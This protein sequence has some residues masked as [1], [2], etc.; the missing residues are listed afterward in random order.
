MRATLR[1]LSSA[2]AVYVLVVATGFGL[3]AFGGASSVRLGGLITALV[4]GA[5]ILGAGAVRMRRIQ[6][7]AEVRYRH[8]VEELPLITYID[9]PVRERRTAAYVSP[10]IEAI[11]GVPLDEWRHDPEAF[12]RHLH[13][14]D[15][16]RVLEAQEQARM[17]GDP[18]DIEY[19]MITRAGDVVWLRDIYTTVHDEDGLPWYTQ[20]FAID[21]TAQKI[22]EHDRE[23]LLHQAQ[24]QNDELRRLDRMKDEFIAL[25]SHELRT[26]LT[27]IRGYLELLVEDVGALPPAQ[28][29]W[30]DVIDRNSIRLQSLVED[31][32]LAAQVEEGSLRLN[33]AS[34]DLAALLADCLGSAAQAAAARGIVLA[35]EVGGVGTV[36]GD[37][38]RVA[39]VIDNVVSNALKFTPSGGRV[40]VRAVRN[41]RVVRIDIEDSG[42]GIPLSEQPQ[43][44]T[45]FF[46]G[47][48]AQADAIVGAGLGLSIAKAIVEAHDGS[49][50]FRSA[51]GSGTTFVIELPVEGPV[52][53]PT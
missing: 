16:E 18:L 34:F 50:T 29:G 1:R 28:R 51:E 24:L 13:P 14:Q 11:I 48:R 38:G 17:T 21:I 37:G 8:L 49:I 45:R 35:H 33:V 32:L 43:L 5:L 31:L 9:S 20:G 44:F 42:I 46:R 3:L 2:R 39:Q 26:P 40:G 6:E 25:V 41:G 12:P 7:V 36:V 15:R 4:G 19:R 47:E 23:Q 30:I 22:A 10:Q 53:E 27:S 52:G